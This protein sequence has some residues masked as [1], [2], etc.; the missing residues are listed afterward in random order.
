MVVGGGGAMLSCVDTRE[1]E[2]SVKEEWWASSSSRCMHMG[3]VW[4]ALVWVMLA[5]VLV[6]LIVLFIAFPS[7]LHL[8]T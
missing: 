6:G 2:P 1:S 3:K 8:L 7:A 4:R 5:L